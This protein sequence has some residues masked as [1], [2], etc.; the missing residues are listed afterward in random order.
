MLDYIELLLPQHFC[1]R[2]CFT[3]GDFARINFLI[4]IITSV[5]HSAQVRYGK[6]LKKYVIYYEE[7]GISWPRLAAG[8]ELLS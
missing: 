5:S 6:S 2:L 3:L 7:T 1:Y 8:G 4:F